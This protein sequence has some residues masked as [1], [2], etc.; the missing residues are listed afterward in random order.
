MKPYGIVCAAAL[1]FGL[2][3]AAA[4]GPVDGKTDLLCATLR[5]V[6]CAAAG[7][8]LEGSAEDVNAPVFFHVSFVDG[9]IRAE[10]PDGSTLDTPIQSKTEGEGRIILQGAENGRGWSAIIDTTTGKAVVA[11]VDVGV[12]FSIFAACTTK[13]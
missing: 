11:A 1:V 7:E 2:P 3:V 12:S 10:R 5:T 6:E 9:A 8:C 4:A 13:D